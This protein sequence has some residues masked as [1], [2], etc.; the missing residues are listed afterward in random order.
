MSDATGSA[1]EAIVQWGEQLPP[2]RSDALRRLLLQGQLSEADKLDLLYMLKGL[3]GLSDLEGPVPIP[4]PVRGDRISGACLMPSA[5]LLK[6]M[7]TRK[8]NAIPDGSTLAFGHTGLTAIYGENGSGKSGYARA[9]K[10][11]CNARDTEER[12]LPN[13]YSKEMPAPA[14][15][16]FKVSV[17]GKDEEIVWQD[18]SDGSSIL[19]NVCVFDGRCARIILDE[20]NEMTYLP[21][22]ADVFEKLVDLIKDLRSRLEKEMPKPI[23]PLYPDIPPT[24]EAGQFIEKISQKT[25]AKEI[26]DHCRWTGEDE[27]VL[28]ALNK[29]IVEAELTDPVMRANRVRSL[30]S[31]V[32]KLLR[33]VEN[34][35][36]FLGDAKEKQINENMKNL[37]EA[38]K[39]LSL[40]SKESLAK[41]PLKGAGGDAWQ[42]LYLAAKAYST[43]HAY[44]GRDFPVVA[45]GAVCVLCMQPLS[46]DGKLRMLRFRDFMNKTITKQVEAA[47]EGLKKIRADLEVLSIPSDEYLDVLDEIENR[48]KEL[49][50]NLRTHLSGLAKRRE[51]LIKAVADNEPAKPVAFKVFPR[52]G[53]VQVTTELENEAKQ[54]EES[55]EPAALQKLKNRQAELSARKLASKRK[56]DLENYVKQ[57]MAAYKYSQCLAETEFKSI[58]EKGKEILTT[59]VT[60]QLQVALIQELEA[61]G[62]AYLP[63]GLSTI[64][65]EGETLHKMEL[66]GQVWGAANLSD[67][68]SEGEQRAVAIAGF[69]AELRVCNASCPIVFDDP[70]S[71]LDHRYR[72]KIA[73]RLVKE[74]GTRQVIVFTHDIA[75]L[76]ELETEAGRSGTS[77]SPQTVLKIGSEPGR[78]RGDMPWHTMRVKDRIKSLEEQLKEIPPLST[79]HLEEYNKRAAGLYGLLRETWEAVIEEILFHG[80]VVRHGSEVK[81]LQLRYVT[82]TDEDYKAIY[83]GMDKSSEWMSGH[84]RSRAL[85][86]NRPSPKELTDDIGSLREF[87]KSVKKRQEQ[88]KNE[89]DEKTGPPIPPSG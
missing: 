13:V 40:V 50:V 19:S 86:Q 67:I 68:L 27:K 28:T 82:V 16:C 59:T 60:P 84:D 38:K 31:R 89:R 45:D 43:E 22:G 8:V 26:E 83:D 6:A 4:E 35:D 39:A 71:S 9:L 80:I 33:S 55:A 11:A 34:A 32:Q 24:T 48:K 77:F 70:V 64:G 23:R 85:D 65:R 14:S 81:T 88:T 25:T 54:L 21:Y 2:W 1:L 78:S 63:L 69:L 30:K 5:I 79:I 29:R 87:V 46:S 15:V 47:V 62:A 18:G 52:D 72:A 36:D 10:R 7:T 75:F 37:T 56:S 57:T 20:N 3:Y 58:T 73:A 42:R 49:A 12:I 66:A 76:L 17:A 41:E 44:P 53:L 51:A 61:L 74:A